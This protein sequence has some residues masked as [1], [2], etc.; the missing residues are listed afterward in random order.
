MKTMLKIAIV[1][2][3]RPTY[4]LQY[5]RG[6]VLFYLARFLGFFF[7]N[8]KRIQL[9]ENV[10]F[11][12]IKNFLAS[13]YEAKIL[14]GAQSIIYENARIEAHGHAQIQIG[15]S[16]ILGDV[17]ILSRA[18]I[19]IG[20]RLLTSWNVMLQ[21]YDPHPTSQKLR[22]RQVD[23]MSADFYPHFG[24]RKDVAPIEWSPPSEEIR[25]GDDV[26]LGANCIILKGTRIGSGSI[27]AAAAV[28]TGGSFPER[29]L[30]AGNPARLVKELE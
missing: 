20:K 21:D 16:S 23:K 15:E 5:A 7:I 17:R 19:I 1:L 12:S 10:R 25:I 4:L 14:V 13:S 11:Q 22:A 28:V 18:K 9:G 26:W 6:T 29:S 24:P 3:D 2:R 8:R 27:V 30:I